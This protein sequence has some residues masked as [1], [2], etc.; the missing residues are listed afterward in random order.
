MKKYTVSLSG[1][2]A[3]ITIGKVDEREKKILEE[4]EDLYETIFNDELDFGWS[5]IDDIY[6][7][8]STSDNCTLT[9]ID[10]NGNEIFESTLDDILEDEILEVDFIDKY[11][12]TDEPCLVCCSHEKGNFFEGKI[13]CEE[14]DI[15][16][17]K[18]II[19]EDVGVHGFYLYGSMIG[20]ITYDGEELDN[21]GGDTVGKAFDVEINFNKK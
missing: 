20:S 18:L 7:N 11:F 4:S 21:Y 9:I 14:F 8:F 5:E 3:E 1:Y 10:E 15:K 2:G 6:H 12:E 19:H 16:K 17:L 13:E